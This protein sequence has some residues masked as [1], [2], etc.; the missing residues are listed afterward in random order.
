MTRV[1]TVST[2]GPYTNDLSIASRKTNVRRGEYPIAVYGLGKIGLPVAVAM[3]DLTGAVTGVDTDAR[4][5]ESVARGQPPFDHEPGLADTLPTLSDEGELSATMDGHRAAREASIHIIVVPVPLGTQDEADLSA[6]D[7]VV[8][9]IA[10]GLAPGDLVVIET[11]VPP[12]T[13]EAVRSEL[14]DQSGVTAGQFGV[15]SC[16]ERTSS[17][18]AL[19]DITGAYPRVVGGVDEESTNAA[20]ALYDELIDNEV[21]TV[22]ARTAE[23]VKLFEG[24]YRDVNIALANELARAFDGRGIDVRDVIDAANTQPYCDIHE[25]GA[26]VGGHCIPWYPYFLMQAT[27]HEMELVRTART[28]NE[29][30]P[31]YLAER[32]LTELTLAGVTPSEARVAILGVAYRPNI[33]EIAASPAFPLV[34]Q[35]SSQVADVMVVDPVLE[36]DVGELEFVELDALEDAN[37]DAIVLVTGHDAFAHLSPT[38]FDGC[39]VV[40]G[41]DALTTWPDRAYTIGRDA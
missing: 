4:V 6:I 33:P 26:G 8:E 41:R 28:V 25:P 11:T 29:E 31:R 27:D 19:Q 3:A 1:P 36:E 38:A 7:V 40:D 32:T 14:A 30:M 15:A 13:A 10:T 2:T 34:D 17:G 20:Y 21:I 9:T 5:V 18:R 35:L 23:T 16:P 22:D 12:G 37:P 24:V 39:V